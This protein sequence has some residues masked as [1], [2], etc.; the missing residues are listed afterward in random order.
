MKLIKCYIENFGKL[1]N[2]QYEFQDGLNIIKQQNGFGKTT[3]ATFIKSM[4][5]GLDVGTNVKIEKSDRKRYYP[6]QGGNY[7][8]NIEFEVNGRKYKIERFFGKKQQ[9]DTFKLYNLETNLESSDYSENIG[10]EIFKINKSGF[11]RSVYIPQGQV[12]MEMEDSISA[13]LGNVLENDN[14]INTSE[15]ALKALNEAK[16]FYIKDKG[17]G[18]FIDGKKEQLN[19]LERKLENSKSDELNLITKKDKLNEINSKI[20]EQE[21]IRQKAQSTLSEC[22]EAGR[23]IAK[24]EAYDAIIS[25]FKNTEERLEILE[26]NFTLGS[27]DNKFDIF[28]FKNKKINEI[29]HKKQKEINH[30]KKISLGL[31]ALGIALIIIGI[32]LIVNHLQTIIGIMLLPIGLILGLFYV[33]ITKNL[34]KSLLNLEESCK[35]DLETL[36]MQQ[37]EYNSAI[38]QYEE[39][40]IEKMKFEKENNIFELKDLKDLPNVSEQDLKEQIN[41]LNKSIDIL[42][43]EKNHIKN[44]I[45]ILENQIDENEYLENEIGNLR[46][47]IKNINDKYLILKKTEELLKTAKERFSSSYLQ[48]MVNEFN[49]CLK[50]INREELKTN[51]DINLNVNIDSNGS[52]KE[53]KYYSAGYKDL[54]YICM[55]FSLIKALFKN[56]NPFVVLDDPFTNL[57]ENK[58]SEALKVIRDFSNKYQ[59]IYFVCNS[60]RV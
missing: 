45:D 38:K 47:D 32:S 19:N 20:K 6:W 17:K 10:E 39:A 11:E 24:K 44:Q 41:N 36:K 9:E 22:I 43:D 34:N 5:Y 57:D 54:V 37:N 1:H 15:D 58:T 30:N 51:V 53:I 29:K 59:I 31:I 60:S 8:G 12:Q 35:N 52:Q 16:K 33:I 3:F 27:N 13:K 21:F 56:E 40:K 14:D 55:R 48:D 25:K 46:E 18:G 7:G 49:N 50:T 42:N 4:F 26:N 28:E 23:K 2:F